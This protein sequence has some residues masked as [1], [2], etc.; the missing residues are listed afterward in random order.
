MEDGLRDE[1]TAT[2]QVQQY[3]SRSRRLDQDLGPYHT[4]KASNLQ[5][6]QNMVS[7]TERLLRGRK[8]A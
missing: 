8:N 6:Q 4:Q 3:Q 5:Q 1:T 2:L 7:K